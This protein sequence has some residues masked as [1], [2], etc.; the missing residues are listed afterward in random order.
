MLPLSR[1]ARTCA[2]RPGSVSGTT[3]WLLSTWASSSCPPG[4]NRKKAMIA[5]MNRVPL[6]V[7]FIDLLMAFENAYFSIQIFSLD[8]QTARAYTASGR[9]LGTKDELA[10]TMLRGTGRRGQRGHGKIAVDAAVHVLEAEVGREPPE[11]IQVHIPVDGPEIGVLLG[12]FP[13][14]NLHAA[15]HGVR[16]GLAASYIL[17]LNS[18]VYVVHGEIALHV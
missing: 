8:F 7:R 17:E 14:H 6:L 10:V 12:I 9:V 2:G 4:V 11:E 16:P 15:V 3:T 18:P 13:E 5:D 1:C